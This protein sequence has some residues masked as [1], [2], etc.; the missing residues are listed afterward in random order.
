MPASSLTT[1]ASNRQCAPQHSQTRST[2]L[3]TYSKE[4]SDLAGR[5]KGRA[6]PREASVCSELVGFDLGT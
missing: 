4:R 3:H 5:Y 2:G 1:G 6:G